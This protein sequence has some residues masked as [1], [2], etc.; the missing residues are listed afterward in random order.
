[1]RIAPNELSYTDPSA[2]KDIYLNP[3]INRAD[4]WF[5]K[6]N[7]QEP[8]SI[9]GAN[10]DAHAKFK[11]AFMGGFSDRA[12]RECAG[13]MEGYV[14]AMMDKLRELC[15]RGEGE[16]VVDMVQWLNMVTF[17]VSGDLSFGSS[18]GSIEHGKPHAWVEISNQFGKGI[19]LM[20]S[21]NYY[22]LGLTRLLRRMMPAKTMERM[23]W[24]KQLTHEKVRE[25][26][27]MSEGRKDFVQC[28]LEYNRE[29]S[30]QE[31]G[32]TCTEEEI[33]LNMSVLVFAGSDTTSTAIASTLW[34][35][36]RNAE[37]LS[38]AVE[39][40]RGTFSQEED[41][42]MVT[43]S[44]LEVLNAVISEG[45]RLGPPSAVTVPRIVGKGGEVVCGRRVPEGVSLSPPTIPSS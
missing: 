18:F 20:A 35:L 6:Q 37:W 43:T 15:T 45:M 17:D 27:R 7:P 24:H 36:L 33:E 39:E 22:H 13:T 14:G 32:R 44:K 11:R 16:T 38:K 9:M 29:G 28:V 5:R 31:K 30:V 34:Y 2:W 23:A 4:L 12:T 8:Y 3:R 19:A 42:R 10:E 25:R 26:L 1:M 41:I 40:V 21:L